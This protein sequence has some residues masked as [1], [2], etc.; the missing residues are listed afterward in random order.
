MKSNELNL[1]DNQYHNQSRFTVHLSECIC[2]LLFV[3]LSE[4]WNRAFNLLLGKLR[5]AWK[6]WLAWDMFST[7]AVGCD[8]VC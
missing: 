7:L 3:I 4:S 2:E 6:S 1:M 5:S 8:V